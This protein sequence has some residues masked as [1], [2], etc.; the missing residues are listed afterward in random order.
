[1]KKR[2]ILVFLILL[3]LG[4]L[5]GV[6]GCKSCKG[7]DDP[8]PIDPDPPY[9]D[10]EHAFLTEV[11]PPTCTSKGYTTYTC[12]AGDYSYI[13]DYVNELGHNYEEHVVPFTCTNDGYTR[14]ICSRGDSEYTKE[15][16]TI[17]AHH[18]YTETVIAPT[19]T[20]K[21]YTEGE[22]EVCHN[23]TYTKDT[24]EYSAHKFEDGSCTVC[25]GTDGLEY[26]LNEDGLSY[27]V[28]GKGTATKTLIN[29]LEIYNGKPVTKVLA[30]AFENE[31]ELIGINLPAA[32]TEIGEYALYGLSGVEKLVLP[33]N[34]ES[35]GD[36][37]ISNCINLEELHLGEKL[38]YLGKSALE[39]NR[40]LLSLVF[41]TTIEEIDEY[42]LS[43]SALQTVVFGSNLKKIGRS[44]FAGTNIIS[45]D[46]PIGLESIGD[47]AFI[48]CRELI[49]VKFGGEYDGKVTSLGAYAFKGC[50]KLEII[51][52]PYLTE[53]G[54]GAFESCVALNIA[55]IG[56]SLKTLPANTFKGCLSLTSANVPVSA[57]V[58]GE[59]AFENCVSL[60]TIELHDNIKEIHA[61][62]FRNCGALKGIYMPRQLTLLGGYAFDGCD[63]ISEFTI[64]E[65]LTIISEFAFNNCLSLTH[66][67]IP[68][69]IEEIKNNA[70]KGCVKLFEVENLS[71]LDIVAGESTH[72]CVAEN[73]RHIYDADGES[74]LKVE[75][76]FILYEDGLILLGYLGYAEEIE[77]PVDIAGGSYEVYDYAL[78]KRT[79]KKVTIPEKVRIIGGYAFANCKNLTEICFNAEEVEDF[80]G[81]NH[82]FENIGKSVK[83]TF[84]EKV[85]TVPAYLFYGVDGLSEIIFEEGVCEEIH[86]RAFFGSGAGIV[87]GI[88][89][90]LPESLKSV[91][92]TAFEG[93]NIKELYY[94]PENLSGEP[95]KYAG[96][97]GDLIIGNKV[98]EINAGVF[99]SQEFMKVT[100]EEGAVLES[101]GAGAFKDSYVYI[102][103]YVYD[104]AD[105]S[106][107]AFADAEANPLHASETLYLD[108]ERVVDAIIEGDV[109]SYAFY[110]LG[111]LESVYIGDGA[112]VAP[113]AFENCMFLESISLWSL[114][115][116][117][118]AIFGETGAESLRYITIRSGEVPAEAFMESELGDEL[119]IT[120]GGGVTAIGE[121]AFE[122]TVNL[123]KVKIDK[124]AAGFEI[125]ARAFCGSENLEE[126]TLPDSV[127]TIESEAFSGCISL[128][129]LTLPDAVS[130]IK[131]YVFS[132][133]TQLKRIV[134]S[135]DSELTRIYDKAFENCR[136]LT[137]IVIPAGVQSLSGNAFDG[138]Y[139]LFEVYDL[140]SSGVSFTNAIKVYTSL[141]DERAFASVNGY[142]FYYDINE[143]YLV[144]YEGE[145]TVLSLPQDIEGQGYKIYKYAFA[146]DDGIVSV[147]I[148]GGV[149]ELGM[150]CFYECTGLRY[151]KIG[152]QVSVIRT[153]ALS[154]CT[155]LSAVVYEGS[156]EEWERVSV[157]GDTQ[158]VFDNMTFEG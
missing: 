50:E 28:K 144:G 26:E 24:V 51:S 76:G 78:Y 110:G 155:N 62:A 145:E 20:T 115:G 59:S 132:G 65:T 4:C 114:S 39:D 107:I 156:R 109:S 96:L 112:T 46:L 153:N 95:F 31:T 122:N 131:D 89:V 120:L 105:W 49:E 15:G 86:T 18:V 100:L 140:A 67:T 25:G 138:C 3:T 137:S 7:G 133:C 146:Y 63:G 66:I 82:A 11:T 111:L 135:E 48:N 70:F 125:G 9:I 84:G 88:K 117:M 148:S 118:D 121:S 30:R 97:S 14:M 55:R 85:H 143:Y 16:S 54:L 19:C 23:S 126:V 12:T 42:A 124:S 116:K 32:V 6:V 40:N 36:Y 17:P 72:G 157:E 141:D 129:E 80:A 27:A 37:A 93:C 68:E 127:T 106:K 136:S 77:L 53:L 154:N 134:I 57:E 1:M 61:S 158:G 147:T 90:S 58:I 45:I 41:P 98:K 47:S 99:A 43:G 102:G 128:K 108:G 52:F 103:V 44:A 2:L 29:V 60:G 152:T 81:N 113:N 71:A 35:I 130:E 123:K 79:F 8:D 34:L 64:P 21:G 33:A 56:N 13:D 10:H 75:D 104:L 94:N 101:I 142:L 149:T 83:V 91:D 74:K 150:S 38:K 87:D 151:L 22:C 119:E 69:N 5:L 73:A 92:I 139:R